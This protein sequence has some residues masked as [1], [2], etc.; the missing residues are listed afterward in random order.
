MDKNKLGKVMDAFIKEWREKGFHEQA[1][2]TMGV[3]AGCEEA[4][5]V[6]GDELNS[7]NKL[8]EITKRHTEEQ[9]VIDEFY[10]LIFKD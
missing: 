8:L 6:F 3:L 9:D 5:F 4:V 10:A 2:F 1:I 7:F